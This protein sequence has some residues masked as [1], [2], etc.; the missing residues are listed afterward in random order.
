MKAIILA[1]GSGIK[2]I[3]KEE[4]IPTCLME[5]DGKTLLERQIS[6]LKENGINDILVIVGKEGECWK[7]ENILRIK[8]IAEK[9]LINPLNAKTPSSSS[10]VLG[11]EYFSPSPCL[12]LDGDLIFEE[13]IIKEA[14]KKSHKRIIFIEDIKANIRGTYI[15]I[16]EGKVIKIERDNKAGKRYAGL[17]KLDKILYSKLKFEIKKEKDKKLEYPVIL[18]KYL[19]KYSIVAIDVDDI[20]GETGDLINLRPLIGGSF[21]DTRIISKVVRKSTNVVR[22]EAVVG[23][24]KLADEIKW[25]NNL[26]P[27]IKPYF[28]NI[29]NYKIEKKKAWYE[30][31]YYNLQTFRSLLLSKTINKEQG[32]YILKTMLRLLFLKFNKRICASTGDYAKKVHLRRVIDRIISSAQKS[33]IIEEVINSRHIFINGKKYLNLPAILR[34]IE[35]DDILLKKLEP[36]FLCMVHGDLHFDNFTVDVNQMPLINFIFLDP[37]GLDNTYNYDYDL[38]KLWFSLNGKYDLTHE[39]KFELDYQFEKGDFVS[40][41]KY[42]DVEMFKIFDYLHSEIKKFLYTIPVLKKDKNWEIRTMFGEIAHYCSNMPFHIKGNKKENLAIA[43]YLRGVKLANEFAAKYCKEYNNPRLNKNYV[44]VN[45]LEEYNL[46][47]KIFENE[48]RNNKN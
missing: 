31:E 40:K 33:P 30:M 27:D 16:D 2:N 26:P 9:V 5:I 13:G 28:P 22:K 3:K 34:M 24:D 43:I 38:S 4:L 14:T 6:I 10:L 35:K 18:N 1:A 36:P 32:A 21:A 12:V 8:G 7:R 17:M 42:T 45:S 46:A 19:K 11:L 29:L 44:N 15:R 48:T 37:R 39:G 41:I 23:R 47:K 20:G 25:I